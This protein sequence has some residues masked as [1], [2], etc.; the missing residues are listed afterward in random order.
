MLTDVWLFYTPT[1]KNTT[2]GPKKDKENKR[3]S[4]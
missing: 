1:T 3:K 2:G 4:N